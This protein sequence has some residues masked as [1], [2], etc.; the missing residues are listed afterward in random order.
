MKE[1]PHNMMAEVGI[2]GTLI[3]N[4]E[5]YFHIEYLHPRMFY[6]KEN[7]SIFWA[8]SE[9]AKN[10]V[11]TIDDFSILTKIE[12]NK[13][14]RSMMSNR[15]IDDIEDFIEKAKL[16]A[17]GD[18][19]ELKELARQVISLSFIRDAHTKLE[20]L[21]KDIL[22]FDDKDINESNMYIQDQVNN[23]SER[24]IIGEEIPDHAKA[25]EEAWQ[26]IID[27]R[28][29]DGE[30][31]G[32]P[33]KFDM[34]ADY[35]TYE[36]GEL[37]ILGGRMKAGKSFFFLNEAIHKLKQGI[38]T[39]IFDTEMSYKRWLERFIALETGLSIRNIKRGIYTESEG[40][41]IREKIEWLKEQPFIHIYDPE[42]T[43]D[44]IY[45]KSKLLQRNI[46]LQF[47]IY[48]YIKVNDSN[49]IKVQ[50]HNFLGDMTNFLKNKIAGGLDIAI[51]A[52][53]QMSPYDMRLADSDKL[54]RYASV[55]M[56]WMEKTGEEIM[57]DGE[58]GG[59]YK[60]HIDYNR[61]GE[62]F[63]DDEYI[64]MVFDGN[65]ARVEECTYQPLKTKEN[66]FDKA[67]N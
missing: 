2:I 27:S 65:R 66:V 11:E 13:D 35:F 64:N 38:P 14:I 28:S 17:R 23:F 45:T 51:L 21:S 37:A 4:P 55:V 10:S 52:G 36:S 1:L 7:A 30:H 25:T 15:G 43:M 67:F 3:Q 33:S 61:L 46:G 60:I 29:E 24:Y 39:A 63:R 58:K 59:N 54:N 5:F 22:Q 56:Y 9:L 16:T 62:Q 32:F 20:G 47:L 19:N 53:A 34:L 31:V 50:E 49:S 57:S 41:L 40:Q 48:D 42:W 6:E 12:S 26:D 8:V 44:K 18:L